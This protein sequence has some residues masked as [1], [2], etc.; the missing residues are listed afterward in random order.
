MH[1]EYPEYVA[2]VLQ[3]LEDGG[4]EA[5]IVGGSLRDALLGIPAHDF[6]VATSAKPE[7]T[8]ELFSDYRVIKTGMKHGT[9]TVMIEN[10]PVEITTFRIDGT[11]TDARHPD[12]V[13]FTDRITEDL[14][15]RDFT[16]NAMA[17][18]PT[19]GF[20]DPFGG[21]EDLEARCIRAVR[22]PK[23]RFSEDAL[24]IMR[25]FR[26]SAQLRFEI[27][28][29]TLMGA[30]ACREGLSRI[31][32]ERIL[33]EWVRL[34]CSDGAADAV[35]SMARTGVLPYVTEDISP[36]PRILPLLSC[37][38]RED[39]ARMGMYFF[40]CSEQ[41]LTPLLKDL[42][43]SG[44][45]IKGTLAVARGAG[46]S[47]QSP[48]DAAALIA[49][50]GDYASLA[51]RASVLLGISP[52]EAQTWVQNN[53]T[54]TKISELPVNGKDLEALGLR[55]REIGEALTL[56]LR[57]VMEDPTYNDK[58]ALIQWITQRRA[59]R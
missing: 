24:R 38:P 10:E 34:L 23:L 49:R 18:S 54:P 45:Q 29:A 59:E 15:R 25:A 27:E 13:V 8:V 31:A 3:R 42:K 9:V 43:C 19:R 39:V 52:E 26:F 16:V 35:L 32:K 6:D 56:L 30:Q 12:G 20:V 5:Y 36:E 17:Y 33:S 55:G 44:R 47:V 28:P 40:G 53:R 51:V 50:V 14:S 57:T 1:I 58:E 4:E 7:R 22:D 46:I 37:M 11:Y 48:T 41:R 21:Q 2:T